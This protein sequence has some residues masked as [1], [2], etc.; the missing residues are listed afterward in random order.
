MKKYF[1]LSPI[2]CVALLVM[3]SCKE[4]NQPPIC[5]ITTPANA[6]EY[7]VGDNITISANAED[8]DGTVTEVRFDVNGTGIVASSSFPYSYTW[9]TDAAIAGLYTLKATAYDDENASASDEVEIKLLE[10]PY[11]PT[12]TDIDGNVYNTVLIG[13]QCWMQ[14]NLKVTHY[15]NGDEI[16]NV[17]EDDAWGAL[18][19]NN[20]DDAYCYYDNNINSDYGALYTYAAAIADDWQRDNASDQGICPDGWHLP[21]DAEWNVLSDFLGGDDLAGGK[22]KETGTSH[23]SSPNTGATNECGFTALPGG[24]RQSYYGWF[25]YAEDSGYWRSASEFDGTNSW[26]LSL[27]SSYAYVVCCCCPFTKSHGFSVRCVRN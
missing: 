13:D 21:T 22:M 23:W 6:A 16:P 19:D 10:N 25:G 3:V 2:L 17:T 15:P 12:I 9:E 24:L 8:P 27:S 14:E 20:T 7:K 18:A 5:K 1:F 4:E 11:P 26:N